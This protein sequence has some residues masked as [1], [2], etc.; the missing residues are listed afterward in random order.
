MSEQALDLRRSLHVAWRHK[1]IVGIVAALG[2]L[3]GPGTPRSTR[4]C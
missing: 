4:R 2:F 1:T 3:L